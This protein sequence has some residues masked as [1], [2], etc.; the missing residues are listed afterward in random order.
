[1][2][3][4][5]QLLEKD[6]WLFQTLLFLKMSFM[7]QIFFVI[8]YRSKNHLKISNVVLRF[9]NLIVNFKI[10]TWESWLAIKEHD[11]LHYHED[12]SELHG[13][14]HLTSF[15]SFYVPSNNKI[16]LWHYKLGHPNF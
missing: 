3:L 16:M 6:H 7:F 13:Q 8:Y 15:E 9:F 12:G 4:F 14:A 2:V 1:M 5:Q 11:G 10:W